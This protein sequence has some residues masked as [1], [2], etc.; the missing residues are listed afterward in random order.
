MISSPI[1]VNYERRSYQEK[2]K[3]SKIDENRLENLMLVLK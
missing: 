2:V 1:F 3:T